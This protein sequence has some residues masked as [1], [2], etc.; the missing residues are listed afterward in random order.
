MLAHPNPKRVYVGGGGEGATI[1][2]VLRHKSVE[3][4]VMVDIDEVAV[5]TCKQFLTKHHA[6]AF[7]D[8]RLEL[9]VPSF[10][11]LHILLHISHVNYLQPIALFIV[12]VV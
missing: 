1:R 12:V 7:D 8:P 5:E 3:K 6:G 4:V 11:S 9:I 10:F 2:E